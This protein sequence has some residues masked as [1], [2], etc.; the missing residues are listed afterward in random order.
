MTIT[1]YLFLDK[2]LCILNV[3]KTLR[4]NAL[5]EPGIT[6]TCIEDDSILPPYIVISSIYKDQYLMVKI[7]ETLA[8]LGYDK[9][10]KLLKPIQ[11]LI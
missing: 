10:F 6:Y 4:T 8:Y 9:E 5:L 1:Y 7:T 3:F 2:E 11:S